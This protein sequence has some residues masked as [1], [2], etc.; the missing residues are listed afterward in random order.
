MRR[1]FL[2]KVLGGVGRI[3][4]SPPP[5]KTLAQN[6]RIA[7]LPLSP[8]T[9]VGMGRTAPF[10]IPALPLET[11]APLFLLDDNSSLI[12]Q[13][14][15]PSKFDN[16]PAWVPVG[17]GAGGN[18]AALYG[19]LLPP[20]PV[21]VSRILQTMASPPSKPKQLTHRSHYRLY[22]GPDCIRTD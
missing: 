19:I 21:A 13:P 8:E 12:P 4:P 11:I 5:P 9:L 6:G 20:L 10:P 15:V 18:N 17:S 14:N 7:P 16:Q 22:W 1:S 3:A 2:P